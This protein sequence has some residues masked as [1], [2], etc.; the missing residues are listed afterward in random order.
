MDIRSR[1]TECI[2][3]SPQTNVPVQLLTHHYPSIASK[4]VQELVCRREQS[5]TYQ[6]S[7]ENTESI[8]TRVAA[9]IE[10]VLLRIFTQTVWWLLVYYAHI[11][12]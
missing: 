3:S 8:L 12:Y 2:I 11:I 7:Y 5:E 1:N 4:R 9:I 6:F 10:S